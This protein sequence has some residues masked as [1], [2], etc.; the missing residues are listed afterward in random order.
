MDS[1]IINPKPGGAGKEWGDRAGRTRLPYFPHI[2][3]LRA[4]AIIPVVLYHLSHSWCPGGFAGVDVFFVISGYLI[5]RRIVSDLNAGR[6]SIKGFYVR[7]I[8]RI[9]PAYFVVTACVTASLPFLYT[10]YKYRS[11]S[12]T[13]VYSA[14]FSTNLYFNG[15]IS[16]VDV[17]ARQNPLLHLWS[18]SIEEQ[19]YLAVPVFILLLWKFR[20][21]LFL[22]ALVFL[23]AAS[24]A[25]SCFCISHG[26][27]RYAFFM[28]PSR[29]WELLAG[30]IISQI[31]PLRVA[32]R[33]YWPLI[34]WIGLGCILV[35]YT[36]Y[37]DFTFFPGWAALPSV[38][39]AALLISFGRRGPLRSLLSCDPAV[40]VGKVSYSLYLWH[41][42]LFI[43]SGGSLSSIRAAEGVA[44]TLAATILSYKF[45]ELPV[46]KNKAFG[47]RHAFTML[48]AGSLLIACAGWLLTGNAATRNGEL[49]SKWRGTPT[50]LIAEQ[51]R[52]AAR[53]SC[54]FEDLK[55]ENKKVLVKIGK[56]D[57]PPG[58]V[59]WG[60][61]FALALL[62]GVDIAA[63]ENGRAGFFINLKHSLTL[64]AAI[65]IY[66]FHPREDREPVIRWLE[67]R[68]DIIDVFLVN[69]WFNQLQNDPDAKET[70]L[71][72]ERLHKAGKHVFFFNS[73]PI[74]NERALY[75]LSLGKPVDPNIGAMSLQAYETLASRQNEV[76]DELTRLGFATVIPINKAFLDGA[77][78]Y[79]TTGTESFYMDY[80]HLNKA[81]AL[82]AMRFAAPMIWKRISD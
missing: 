7:R 52:D 9:I 2:D 58:F 49:P 5:T 66:P 60:D 37:N 61:S 47:A 11:I 3:G 40:L 64:N 42:P 68:P 24:F 19:Y 23:F 53:S 15:V 45:V 69:D 39:G 77:S 75:P 50:W 81:G 62:P 30:S 55:S 20:R 17:N 21:G 10:A 18:L 82:R 35:P 8:K 54:S 76:A 26:H 51:A 56:V 78:Y 27:T 65:G 44:A 57:A 4:L 31:S 74:S 36:V 70:V 6:F 79:T 38:L 63:A 28:L 59:L 13:A 12:K 32:R 34:T 73:A 67:S 41:W 22:P 80:N 72:A 43:I 48:I 14:F 46:R 25:F 29:A 33:A 16:Y 71:I 1:L